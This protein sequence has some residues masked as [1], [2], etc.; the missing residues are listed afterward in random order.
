MWFAVGERLANSFVSVVIDSSSA[1][2]LLSGKKTFCIQVEKV[3]T[4]STSTCTARTRLIIEGKNQMERQ[5]RDGNI[6]FL[7]LRVYLLYR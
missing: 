4:T 7:L 5:G 6:F 3:K 2:T 1:I